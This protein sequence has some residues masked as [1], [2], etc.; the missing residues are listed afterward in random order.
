M[1]VRLGNFSSKTLDGRS[2]TSNSSSVLETYAVREKKNRI[3]NV[4]CHSLMDDSAHL[5]SVVISWILPETCEE[6][7][8]TITTSFY[9]HSSSNLFVVGHCLDMRSCCYQSHVSRRDLR[10]QLS[11]K[12]SFSVYCMT[13][14]A[15]LPLRLHKSLIQPFWY[16][17]HLFNTRHSRD[18]T[19]DNHETKCFLFFIC[20]SLLRVFNKLAV[21]S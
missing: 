12:G 20:H 8:L 13:P 2:S 4:W 11:K 6:E 14:S 15:G 10:W 19:A 21:S 9:L 18:A 1:T 7:C 3:S 17:L 16:S 5:L